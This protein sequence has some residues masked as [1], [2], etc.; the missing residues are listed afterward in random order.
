MGSP[1]V[2]YFFFPKGRQ[3]LCR[4][5]IRRKRSLKIQLHPTQL[6][7][8]TT[9]HQQKLQ[10]TSKNA[11]PT[12]KTSKKLREKPLGGWDT[13]VYYFYRVLKLLDIFLD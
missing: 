9:S 10:T 11:T 12:A 13:S 6:R 7:T 1:V 8:T 4:I 3:E 5:F 2:K